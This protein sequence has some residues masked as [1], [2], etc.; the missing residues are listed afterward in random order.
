M[1]DVTI[2]DSTGTTKTIKTFTI[3]GKEFQGFI[4][5]D[6]F[7]VIIEEK[8]YRNLDLGTTGQ[9]VKNATGTLYR[10]I[11]QNRYV[12]AVERFL[13][14]YDKATAAT[15]GDTPIWTIPL[16]PGPAMVIALEGMKFTSGISIRA[17]TGLADADTG[18]PGT[19]EVVV[20]LGYQ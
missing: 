1:S 7:G 19:G 6:E 4:R 10:I 15:A 13:K 3:G 17:T 8:P 11:A 18:A 20:N 2:L 16:A 14:I 12:G 5:C 9:V